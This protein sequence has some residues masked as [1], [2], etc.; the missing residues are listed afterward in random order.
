MMANTSRMTKCA[1]TS[2]QFILINFYHTEYNYNK[3]V[4]LGKASAVCKEIRGKKTN[5]DKYR[6][7]PVIN[8]YQRSL[9]FKQHTHSVSKCTQQY[10]AFIHN[11]QKNRRSNYFYTQF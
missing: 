6:I 4:N 1:S 8:C 2:C 9:R 11:I 7:L 10:G 5:K 3:S